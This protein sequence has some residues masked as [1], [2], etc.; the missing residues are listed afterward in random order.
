MAALPPPPPSSTYVDQGTASVIRRDRTSTTTMM[1]TM[2][3]ITTILGSIPVQ[4]MVVAHKTTR[5]P[6]C[7]TNSSRAWQH[8]GER[9]GKHGYYVPDR[10]SAAAKTNSASLSARARDSNTRPPWSSSFAPTT[11]KSARYKHYRY[12]RRFAQIH[13]PRPR[14]S[15]LETRDA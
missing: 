1:T 5:A 7:T 15:R 11:V 10:D 6:A 4:E 8:T 12:P 13:S 3:M 2:M 14:G 9:G